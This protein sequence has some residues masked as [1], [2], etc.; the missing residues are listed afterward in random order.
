LHSAILEELRLWVPPGSWHKKAKDGENRDGD[1]KGTGEVA[2]ADRSRAD[3]QHWPSR[4]TEPREPEDPRN[5]DDVTVNRERL[6][7][8]WA[9]AR[10]EREQRVF[11]LRWHLGYTPSEI[12]ARWPRMYPDESRSAADISQMIQNILARYYRQCRK[13]EGDTGRA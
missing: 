7:D 8:I 1:E 13:E 6:R 3:T 5:P 2:D 11:V 4:A 10:G 9:C 12:A